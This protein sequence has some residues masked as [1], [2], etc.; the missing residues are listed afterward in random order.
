MGTVFATALAHY[1]ESR[2]IVAP[3]ELTRTA[4]G[5]AVVLIGVDRRGIGRD[6]GAVGAYQR[7]PGEDRD[8]VPS[9][10]DDDLQGYA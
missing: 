8:Q 4:K 7:A 10:Y 1:A 5:S 2:T 6:D 3:L 9:G